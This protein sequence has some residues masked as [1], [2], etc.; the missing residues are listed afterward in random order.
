[1][2]STVV[3]CE[4]QGRLVFQDILGINVEIGTSKPL[5]YYVKHVRWGGKVRSGGMGKIGLGVQNVKLF[6]CKI[7]P[8]VKSGNNVFREV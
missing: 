8:V 5:Y 7:Y 1:M 2:R 3:T 4:V 6:G